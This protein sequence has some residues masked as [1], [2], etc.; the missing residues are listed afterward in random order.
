MA[1]QEKRISE[2]DSLSSVASGDLLPI[3]DISDTSAGTTKQVTITNLTTAVVAAGNITT[4]GNTFN[5]VS[6]LVQLNGSTQLPAVSGALVT[7][8]NADNITSGTFNVANKLVQL[9]SIGRLPAISGNLLISLNASNFTGGTLADARLSAQVTVQGNTFNGVSQL[10]Q[11]DGSTRFPAANGSL[12]TNLNATAITSGTLA[13]TYLSANVALKT[14]TIVAVA[15][16]GVYPLAD[17]NRDSIY[18]IG[19]GSGTV[20]FN[21]PNSPVVTSGVS[22]TIITNT[23]EA[24]SFTC[25]TSASAYYINQ[26]GASITI[27]SAGTYAPSNL[28]GRVITVT[29]INTNTYVLSGSGL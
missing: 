1:F 29:C 7:N 14:K 25:D 26:A 18:V 9:D 15:S 10:V 16:A 12:I 22:F 21:L 20:N 11:L 27:A 23:V 8:L 28:R 13:D 3:V 17:L 5:G 6:Q 2:L 19:H 4:Q 24:I